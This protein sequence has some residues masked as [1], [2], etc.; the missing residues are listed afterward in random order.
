[1]P[2]NLATHRMGH[3]LFEEA[4]PPLSAAQAIAEAGRCLECG[5]AQNPAPCLQACPAGVNVPAFVGAIA[6]NQAVRAAQVIWQANLLGASCARVCP[7]EVLCEGHCVLHHEGRPPVEIARLQ[8]HATDTALAQGVPLRATVR[9]SKAPVAVIGAGPAG[10]AAAGELAAKGH[11][12]TVFEA[13]NEPGGLL[14]FAIAPYRQHIEPLPQEVDALKRLGVEFRFGTPVNSEA[15]LKHIESRYTAIV[16]AVGLGQDVEVSYEGDHLEGVWDSLVFI[17]AI[18]TG[19]HPKVGS[20][21]AVIGGGNTAMDVAREALR[22]GATAVSVLYRRTEDEMPAFAHEVAEARQEGVHFQWLTLPLRFL[23]KHRLEGVECQYMRLG[24]PDSS[25]RK[26]PQPV[27]G[28][29]FVLPADTVIKAIGQRPRLEF[30]QWIEGLELRKGQIV[31]NPE[32]GQTSNPRYF[33]AGDA[34][35][36]ATVVEAVRGAKRVVA[37][38][39]AALGVRL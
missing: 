23:G 14:R 30:L 8:R 3:G 13:R 1:M 28:T 12:V 6:R 9:L 39:E 7:T 38:I 15:M 34:T 11:P 29:E 18:K 33:A 31:V 27:P 2:Q 5:S 20:Q 17:E 36:G 32:T 24:E 35:G 10:L 22:L 26:S 21:V 37:G 19:H 4:K 16:L 25:G